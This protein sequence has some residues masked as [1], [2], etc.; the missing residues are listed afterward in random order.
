MKDKRV[1]PSFSK[2]QW[3]KIEDVLGEKSV[4][5]YITSELLKMDKICDQIDKIELCQNCQE[6]RKFALGN[7]SWEAIERI[8]EK[9][10]IKDPSTIIS[11]LILTPLLLKD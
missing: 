11:R 10:G 4:K 5:V 7:S 2:S 9:T 8:K 3:Q 1:K 6:E